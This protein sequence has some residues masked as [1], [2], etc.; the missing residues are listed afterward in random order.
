MMGYSSKWDNVLPLMEGL[1][2][3][4]MSVTTIAT[5]EC[6]RYSSAGWQ[7]NKILSFP[8]SRRLVKVHMT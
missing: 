6:I 1:I 8:D 7:G 3:I 2:V 4:V 5:C